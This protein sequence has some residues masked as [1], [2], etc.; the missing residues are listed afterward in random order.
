MVIFYKF[1]DPFAMG[2]EVTRVLKQNLNIN[3]YIW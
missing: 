1:V 2:S 3:A